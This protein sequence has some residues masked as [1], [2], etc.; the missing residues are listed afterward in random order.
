V[1]GSLA[2]GQERRNESGESEQEGVEDK[3]GNE[4]RG[5]LSMG[6][7]GRKES[8]GKEKGGETWSKD[9]DGLCR[10]LLVGRGE[11]PFCDG[12]VQSREGVENE[13]RNKR[14]EKRE[15]WLVF[16]VRTSGTLRRQGSAVVPLTC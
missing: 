3:T 10:R 12:G 2:D 1:G 11:Q 7:G 16:G 6:G 13:S 9:E 5:R 4:D 14:I 15:L 8:G